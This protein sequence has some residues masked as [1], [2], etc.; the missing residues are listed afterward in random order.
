MTVI[1]QNWQSLWEETVKESSF[2]NR[3]TDLS[4]RE[5][6]NFLAEFYYKKSGDKFGQSN[7]SKRYEFI[8]ELNRLKR[9]VGR[10]STVLDIG[11]GTGRLAL[12]LA[13]IAR[14][15]TVLEPAELS[16]IQL[17]KNAVRERIEN[18]GFI[19]C[20]WSDYSILDK[21]DLVFSAWCEAIRDPSALL[22]MH[23]TSKGYCSIVMNATPYGGDDFFNSIY[24]LVMNEQYKPICSC[25][26]II[27]TLYQHGIYPNMETWKTESVTEYGNLDE[28]LSYWKMFLMNY[29]TVTDDME[30]PLRDYY[31]SKM[32]PDGS[33]RYPTEGVAC[34]IW[35]HV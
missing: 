1:T 32:N 5:W 9:L 28:A 20:L 8:A 3:R 17:R 12:P 30:E 10:D 13:K 29:T 34:M 4:E 22:K 11:A 26:H 27:S 23:Q 16:M 31:R 33:Y 2:H 24:R 18:L 6:L 7:E 21:Y 19:E 35:W 15:V 25:I 14:K